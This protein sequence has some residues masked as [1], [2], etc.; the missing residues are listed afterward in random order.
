MSKKKMI[1]RHNRLNLRMKKIMFSLIL[2]PSVLFAQGEDLYLYC[3]YDTPWSQISLDGA[4]ERALQGEVWQISETLLTIT[5][6]YLQKCLKSIQQIS[7]YLI[8]YF[9]LYTDDSFPGQ[10]YNAD[11]LTRDLNLLDSQPSTR[12]FRVIMA[13]ENIDLYVGDDI[14]IEIDRM[15]G[16]FAYKNDIEPSD[17]VAEN[18][19]VMDESTPTVEG[20]C[21]SVSVVD[22]RTFLADQVERYESKIQIIEETRKF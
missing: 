7:S 16:R 13:I 11:D 19:E 4:T 2:L 5:R 20:S 1:A 6:T 14:L 15:S 12:D 22:V 18:T 21:E 17:I 8:L 9:N 10:S 3:Q